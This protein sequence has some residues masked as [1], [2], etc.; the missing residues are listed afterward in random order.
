MQA[1]FWHQRWA[2]DQIGFHQQQINPYLERFWPSL[3]LEQGAVVLVP[4]C[5]KT[6]DLVWLAQQG[7]SVKGIELSEKAIE[8]FFS[9]HQ[10][11][12][13][14]RQQGAFKVYSAGPIELWCG[15]FFALT[16][17]DVAD[18]LAL[19]DRAALIALPTDMRQ[20]YVRH[21]GQILCGECKGLL[22]TLDY[23]QS[24]IDGPPFSVPDEEVQRL[25]TPDWQLEMLQVCDVLGRSWK[26]VQRGCSRLDERVY[27]L[28]RR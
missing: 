11:R 3:S 7:L 22:I 8:D 9:E 23:E 21:L 20:R 1:D 10:L 16:A 28:G 25:F 4:L 15:D 26:F 12:P 19:Y 24:Q 27:R 2:S 5:G 18:C 13:A 17:A 6:L 14:T